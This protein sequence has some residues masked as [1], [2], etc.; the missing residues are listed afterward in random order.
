MERALGLSIDPQERR[1]GLDWSGSS[2]RGRSTCGV[3]LCWSGC[4]SQER[5]EEQRSIQGPQRQK[6]KLTQ[7]MPRSEP[8]PSPPGPTLVLISTS[9]NV[10]RN[11]ISYKITSRVPGEPE[12]PFITARLS[13]DHAAVARGFPSVGCWPMAGREANWHLGRLGYFFHWVCSFWV[14]RHQVS[15]LHE[16]KESLQTCHVAQIK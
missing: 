13:G 14:N 8:T 10:P 15:S 9:S 16:P 12:A 11:S 1:E 3:S 2:A 7:L 5:A 4:G 6:W